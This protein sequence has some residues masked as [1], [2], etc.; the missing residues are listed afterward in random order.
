MAVGESVGGGGGVLAPL[1][2]GAFRAL[3]AG[4]ILMFLGS[5]LASVALA[6]AVLDVT[7]SL[8]AVGLVVGARSVANIALLLLGGVIADRVSRSLVLRGGCAA[9]AA[10]QVLL[11]LALLSGFAT[12]PLMM[13]L[14]VLNGAAG[15]VNLP[16]ASA[17]VPQTVP[18][19]LLRPAN[20]VVR[21]GTHG[22]MFVGMSAGGVLAGVAGSG[23]AIAASGALFA[24]AGLSFLAL[25]IPATA[26]AGGGGDIL[27]DLREGWTEFT[28]R[29]WVW[30]IV[31][32]FMV[33]NASW[34]ATTAVLGPAIAD[35]SFG[36]TAWGLL[37]AVNSAGLLVGGVTAARWQPRRALLFGT[38]LVLLQT[39]P[40]FAL[41][42]PSP[43]PLLFAAMFLAGV[44]VEQFS[45]AWEVSV[46][47]NI[48]AEKLSRVYSYDA[49]GSFVAM[50]VGQVAVAPLAASVGPG[51]AIVLLA[52]LTLTAVLAALCAPSVRALRRR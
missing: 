6:F 31:L 5:G 32:A 46:Q 1:R 29:S 17:L 27:R 13:L 42:G 35:G 2:H 9:A 4:R 48:P 10:S 49:V 45:V 3:A 20:A 37:M 43:L 51:T 33:V 25:R 36:R 38:G 34:S 22:G 15:A 23:W 24:A 11:A 41:A 14:A 18:R 21:V 39:V 12:L 19:P 47:E 52:C 30:I 40:L 44:A 8:A 7:G 50:P 28:A 16:A 26:P